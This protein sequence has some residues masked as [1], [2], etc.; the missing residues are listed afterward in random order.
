MYLCV[1]VCV[2]MRTLKDIGVKECRCQG[3]VVRESGCQG[4]H[5]WAQDRIKE[6]TFLNVCVCT[7]INVHLRVERS[8]T[9]GLN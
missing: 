8:E 5:Y 1:S 3:I 4:D 2:L 9:S 7:F 6:S